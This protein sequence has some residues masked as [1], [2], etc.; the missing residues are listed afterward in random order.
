MRARATCLPMK[1]NWGRKDIFVPCRS[2]QMKKKV[3]LPCKMQISQKFS[4][5]FSLHVEW[6]SK[7]ILITRDLHKNDNILL[8]VDLNKYQRPL[9]QYPFSVHF[10]T[11]QKKSKKH[12]TAVWIVLFIQKQAQKYWDFIYL[13]SANVNRRLQTLNM[14]LL[15]T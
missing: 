9:C 14:K 15:H 12:E 10:Q 1:A 3:V 7:K 4:F 11:L 5:F 6:R 8:R 2:M 13:S